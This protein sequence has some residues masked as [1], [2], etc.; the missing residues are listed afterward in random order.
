MDGK[1]CVRKQRLRPSAHTAYTPEL[2]AKIGK[3][4]AK[5]GNNAAIEKFSK[6]TRKPVSENTVRGMK[7]SYYEA[8]KHNP[9]GEVVTRLEHGLRGR[10][11]KLGNLDC[12][13]QD[14]IR[15]LRVAGGIVNRAI[16]YCHCCCNRNC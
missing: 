9:K 15:K 7:K 1:R 14:Y 12:N 2:R 8:L 3:F 13:V 11:L 4:A 6:M 5:S 10:H 16:V